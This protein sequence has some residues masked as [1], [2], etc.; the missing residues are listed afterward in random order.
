MFATQSHSRQSNGTV[1]SPRPEDTGPGTFALELFYDSECPLCDREI[2]FLRRLDRQQRVRF[3]DLTQIDFAAKE[4][5]K[6][7]DELMAKIHARLPDGTWITGVE[8]FRRV[9]S[10]VGLKWLVM[11]TRWPVVSDL[12]E[13]GYRVFARNRL[14]WTGRCQDACRVPNATSREVQS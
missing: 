14:R 13:W 1:S 11:P 8:V 5:E 12:V 3:T 6:S 10:A 7:Y 2:A 4:C 9:Y